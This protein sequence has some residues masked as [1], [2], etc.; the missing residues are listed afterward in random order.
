VNVTGQ[1][2]IIIGLLSLLVAIGVKVEFVDAAPPPINPA[3]T[4]FSVTAVGAGQY[5][6]CAREKI[7]FCKGNQCT[8]IKL[9]NVPGQAAAPQPTPPAPPAPSP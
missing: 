6:M 8:V 5:V 9:I 7:F 2:V 1:G 4:L 3:A